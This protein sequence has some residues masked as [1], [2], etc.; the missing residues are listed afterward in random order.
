MSCLI[1]RGVGLQNSGCYAKRLY[2]S[3][4]HI[5]SKISPSLLHINC[6]R[7]KTRDVPFSVPRQ[8]IDVTTIAQV[9]YAEEH[10]Q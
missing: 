6:I 2:W 3:Q 5:I 1:A 4:M 10:I 9:P 8:A 7:L